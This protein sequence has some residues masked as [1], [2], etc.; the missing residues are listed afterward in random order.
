[1]SF[2]AGM[3]SLATFDVHS[4]DENFQS[5]VLDAYCD[6]T[7][8][9]FMVPTCFC[10]CGG[11]RG[12]GNPVFMRGHRP[13]NV[14]KGAFLDPKTLFWGPFWVCSAVTCHNSPLLAHKS[15]YTPSQGVRQWLKVTKNQRKVKKRRSPPLQMLQQPL[16]GPARTLRSPLGT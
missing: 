4:D 8:V 12:L 9:C 5:A 3:R 16:R 2:P 13:V 15:K 6:I 1:M 7:S 14:G 11:V 10:M